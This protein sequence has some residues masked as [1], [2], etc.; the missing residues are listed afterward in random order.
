MAYRGLVPS[1]NSTG[2]RV[3]R[4][5]ITKSG[6]RRARRALIEGAWAYRFPARISPTLQQRLNG[7]PK[8]VVDFAWKA[9]VR[10]CGR[11]RKLMANGKRRTDVVAAI[12]R[13]M[14]AFLWAIGQQVKPR[15]AD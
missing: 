10:L 12:A 2:E 7:L 9:Q 8:G 3:R 14:S 5:G 1:E 4:G 13:E 6:N 11:Y 15:L